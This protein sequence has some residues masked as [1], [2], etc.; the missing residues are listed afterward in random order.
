MP[1]FGGA[2]IKE[3]KHFN[4]QS[5]KLITFLSFSSNNKLFFKVNSKDTRIRNVNDQVQN[6]EIVDVALVSLLL[7]LNKFL[8]FL[9]CFYC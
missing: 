5:V 4:L 9:N 3:E 7:T 1:I 2:Y 8:F 6:K